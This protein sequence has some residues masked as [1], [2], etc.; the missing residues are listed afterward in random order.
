MRALRILSGPPGLTD[1]GVVRKMHREFRRLGPLERHALDSSS[2]T[3]ET[4]AA[5][6]LEGLAGGRF[7]VTP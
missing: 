1:E 6:V 7:R 2:L 3:P 4:T 5:A